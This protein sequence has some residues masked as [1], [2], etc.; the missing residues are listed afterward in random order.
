LIVLSNNWRVDTPV[1]AGTYAKARTPAIDPSVHS[2]SVEDEAAGLARRIRASNGGERQH[3][4]A[5]LN[6]E[7]RTLNRNI[8]NG[9]PD[10]MWQFR[11]NVIRRALELVGSF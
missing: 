4:L 9:Y 8:E 2:V 1:N 11:I 5:A 10:P 7:L 3:N 6:A